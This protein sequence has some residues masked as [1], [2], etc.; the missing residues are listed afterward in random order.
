VCAA[1]WP[2]DARQVHRR[3]H[4]Q[5]ETALL[6]KVEVVEEK[7][8]RCSIAGACGHFLYSLRALRPDQK[9]KCS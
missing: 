8:N 9:Q 6:E 4:S 7:S 3:A 2:T 5:T 1:F